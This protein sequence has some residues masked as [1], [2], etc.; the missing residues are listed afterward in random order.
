MVA[1][2]FWLSDAERLR[3]IPFP[4]WVNPNG[5]IKYTWGGKNYATFDK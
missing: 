2:G 5:G 4:D 1:Q 3:D